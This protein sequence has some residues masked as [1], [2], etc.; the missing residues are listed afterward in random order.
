MSCYLISYDLDGEKKW[1]HS[2]LSNVQAGLMEK[3]PE[4]IA[5]EVAYGTQGH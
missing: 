4:R 3:E 1:G 5:A 2:T